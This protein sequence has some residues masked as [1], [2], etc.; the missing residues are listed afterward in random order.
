MVTLFPR[1][2]NRCHRTEE[3]A[4]HGRGWFTPS[5]REE[6]PKDGGPPWARPRSLALEGGQRGDTRLTEL[7]EEEVSRLPDI[8]PRTEGEGHAPQAAPTR[9]ALG[10]NTHSTQELPPQAT[11]A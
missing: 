6:D 10:G 5:P 4:R 9:Q 1:D 11:S 7:R 2:M 3:T 8:C